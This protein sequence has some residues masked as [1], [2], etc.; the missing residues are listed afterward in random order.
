MTATVRVP[1]EMESRLPAP[2]TPWHQRGHVREA[3]AGWLFTGPAVLVY[4]IFFIA[5]IGM[6][7]WASLL[8]WNGQ[9]NPFVDFDFIGLAN[10]R[11]LLTEDGLLRE[12]FGISVRNTVYF[13]LIYVPGVVA[14]AFGLALVVNSRVLKGRGFFRTSFYFPSITSSVAISVTFLFLFT[15]TGV[16]NSILAWFGINGPSWF[17]DSR[18]LVHIA[19]DGLGIA[20]PS[21]PPGWLLDH[22]FLGVSWWQWLAGP[23]VAMC[24]LLFLLIWTSSG[25]YMLFFLAGLQNIPMEVDEAAAIDG[26]GPWRRFRHITVP[27]MRNRLVLVL[28]LALIGSWQVFD[29]VFIMTQ[30][31]P[32]KTTLT[33]S[34]LSYT[35]SF[36]DGRFGQGAAIAFTLFAIILVLTLVQRFITR[37]RD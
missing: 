27:M 33:P 18:G 32:G 15:S 36:G 19:L 16:I 21:D 12:D 26:A 17:Q 34:Y 9:T 31:G 13:M 22:E 2:R 3:G 6:A 8:D 28:T 24:A 10:Y 29:S 30:G 23:S 14:L 7:L 25:T 20:D 5:P 35:R 37:E 1:G 11:Q 4:A